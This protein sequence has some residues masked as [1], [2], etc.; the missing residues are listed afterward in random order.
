[1]TKTPIERKSTGRVISGL[2][3]LPTLL[4]ALFSVACQDLD[5]APPIPVEV[6]RSRPSTTLAP[7]DTINVT[8]S[9]APELN[10]TQK[11]QTNGKVSL[12]T[13]GDVNAS[14]RTITGLQ[15]SLTSL[16]QPHLQDPT[17]VVAL[18]SAAAGV[19]VSGEVLNPGKVALDRPMTA[20]EAIM[21]SGGFSKFANPKKVYVVRNEGGKNKRYV[22]N[23]DDALSGMNSS[24]FYVRPYDVIYVKQSAW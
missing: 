13:I 20:L 10:T 1:M 5:P 21:E 16:Y 23:M 11:I 7:G 19:Y 22:L 14:G 3:L 12:P 2:L 9:G 8:F 24:A 6:Y 15:S 4:L 18:E 17:V